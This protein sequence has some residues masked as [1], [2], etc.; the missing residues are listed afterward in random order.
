MSLIESQIAEIKHFHEVLFDFR[1]GCECEIEI[2]GVKLSGGVAQ[3][4]R[5]LAT[6]DKRITKRLDALT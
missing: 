5:G 1:G 3:V 2:E 4:L 6:R